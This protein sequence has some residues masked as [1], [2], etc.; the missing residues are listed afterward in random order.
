MEVG[1]IYTLTGFIGPRNVMYLSLNRSIIAEGSWYSTFITDELKQ[2]DLN[3]RPF[4]PGARF[5][6]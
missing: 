1:K 2:E 6:K 4:R 3:K 5:G